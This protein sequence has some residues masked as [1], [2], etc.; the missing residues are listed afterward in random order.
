MYVPLVELMKKD[1]YKGQIL[2]ALKVEE[3]SDTVNLNDDHLELIFGLE[4]ERESSQ[5]VN[6]PPF[7]ISL[8]IHDLIFHNAMID[9]GASHNLMHKVIMDN[10]GLDI[11][12]R[13]KYFFF[14][15]L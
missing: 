3:V 4:V 6:V 11:T 10:L 7:Y 8:N 5:E 2:K 14:F 12:K 15:S 9:L 1:A 13:Y